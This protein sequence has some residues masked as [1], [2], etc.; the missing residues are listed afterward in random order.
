MPDERELL[1]VGDRIL[2][3]PDTGKDRTSGGLYLPQGM[4]EKEKVNTGYV[5][6]T[7]PGYIIPPHHEGGAPWEESKDEP[8][9]V[10]LQVKEGDFAIYLRREAV[11]IEYDMKKYMIVPH[12]AILAV[13]RDKFVA[14]AGL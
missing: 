9:Y 8:R 7:G 14:G 12:A 11:E 2:I 1:I 5:I 3:A 10:P 4:A 13:V 6:K